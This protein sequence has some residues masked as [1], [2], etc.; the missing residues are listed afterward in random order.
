MEHVFSGQFIENGEELVLR[1]FVREL[2][3][4]LDRRLLALEA[5]AFGE[6]PR[7]LANEGD[8]CRER[9]FESNRKVRFGHPIG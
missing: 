4:Q 2:A 5:Q 9:V 7:R 1:F 3:A 8:A 6:R